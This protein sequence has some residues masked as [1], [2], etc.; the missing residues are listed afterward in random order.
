MMSIM[1]QSKN[2]YVENR[3]EITIYAEASRVRAMSVMIMSDHSNHVSF[4]NPIVP[5]A[6][7]HGR[8][9]RSERFDK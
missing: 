8:Q 3:T 6:I 2:S 7:S 4:S 9:I 1:N 5:S